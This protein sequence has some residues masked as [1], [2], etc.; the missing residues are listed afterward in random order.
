MDSQLV[1]TLETYTR[2]CIEI[3]KAQNVN[4]LHFEESRDDEKLYNS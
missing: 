2:E 4:N 1:C 3:L